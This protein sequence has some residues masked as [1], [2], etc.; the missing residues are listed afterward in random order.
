M[1]AAAIMKTQGTR[2]RDES[3]TI[4]HARFET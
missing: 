1:Q 4:W 3:T 2:I